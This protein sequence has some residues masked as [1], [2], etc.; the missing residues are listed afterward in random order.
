MVANTIQ[1]YQDDIVKRHPSFYNFINNVQPPMSDADKRLALKWHEIRERQALCHK[2]AMRDLQ[3]EAL[4]HFTDEEAYILNQTGVL[5]S[6][7][8]SISTEQSLPRPTIVQPRKI[9]TEVVRGVEL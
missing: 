8:N 2:L 9:L 3:Y 6:K 5:P 4:P 7:Q 1:E